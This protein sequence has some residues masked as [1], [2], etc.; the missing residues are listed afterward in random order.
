MKIGNLNRRFGW[1]W[2]FLFLVLGFVI[3]TLIGINKEYAA[4]YA[5]TSGIAMQRELLRG[6]HAHGNLL[7]FFNL[8]YAYYID[9]A[10]LSDGLKRTGSILAVI[11]AI[12]IPLGLFIMVFAPDIIFLNPI[13]GIAIILAGLIMAVGHLRQAEVS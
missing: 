12:L 9:S 4:N 11:G 7:S 8:F 10:L 13:G 6:A 3:E 1:A 5:G 2:L